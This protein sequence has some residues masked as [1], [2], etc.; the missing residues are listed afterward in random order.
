MKFPKTLG[1][2]ADKLGR[3]KEKKREAKKIVDAI[4]TEEKALRLHI[5]NTL[6]KSRATGISGK[7]FNVSVVSEDVPQYE[8]KREFQK[9]VVE[10]GSFDL[11]QGRLSKGAINERWEAGEG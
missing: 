1:T 4:E 11:M 7:N 5:I 9:Y 2:C 6:P 3:L 8:D 10:T